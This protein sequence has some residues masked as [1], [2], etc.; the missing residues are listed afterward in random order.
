MSALSAMN[1]K[2]EILP[3]ETI[4]KKKGLLYFLAWGPSFSSSSL[5]QKKCIKELSNS[6]TIWLGIL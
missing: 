3:V 4:V 1:L 5:R 6:A 2:I